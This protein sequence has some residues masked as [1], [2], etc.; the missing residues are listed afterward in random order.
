MLDLNAC[1]LHSQV[2]ALVEKRVKSLSL[3]ELQTKVSEAFI[4][5]EDATMAIYLGLSSS[6][7]VY[8]SGDSGHGKSELV[9]Y[10]LDVYKIP[11]TV[12]VGHNDLPVDALLGVPDMGKL[13][14]ES[15]YK[16]NFERS[17][18]K[19]AGILIGEE[20]AD[21]LPVTAGVL[22]DVL[23]ENGY[24]DRGVKHESLKSCMIVTANRSPQ[25]MVEGESTKALY[26]ERFPIKEAVGWQSYTLQDY[27]KLL[28]LKFPDVEQKVLY[29]MSWLFADNYVNYNNKVSP[30]TAL[31]VVKVYVSS[32]LKFLKSMD[33]V[34]K[35][36]DEMKKL[37][38]LEYSRRATKK[39]LE[40]L[41]K[42]LDSSKDHSK[43]L[44]ALYIQRSLRLVQFDERDAVELKDFMTMLDAVIDSNVDALKFAEI[45]AILEKVKE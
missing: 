34:T 16:I 20:F 40:T 15:E 17:T 28:H 22:K 35:G 32:G 19:D 14:N 27:L 4:Y 31:N 12:I 44:T 38:D 29:F 13:M 9:K 11:Y 37:A 36:I 5:Q 42:L 7:N 3:E 45:D 26:M 6:M 21:I 10:I 39:S 43:L 25:E 1:T 30:R 24:R 18:F 33:V 2:C 41:K 23:T 8:L